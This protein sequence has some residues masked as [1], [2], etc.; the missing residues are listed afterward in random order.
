MKYYER[1]PKRQIKTNRR[2][3]KYTNNS[4]ISV[5]ELDTNTKVQ[6]A[7]AS[8]KAKG[9]LDGLK[10]EKTDEGVTKAPLVVVDLIG[11]GGLGIAIAA[12]ILSPGGLLLDIV[13]SFLTFF[14][15]YMIYQKVRL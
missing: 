5:M 15:P 10:G 1:A 13:G 9:C 3:H 4:I 6:I 12:I 2:N 8:R 14:A 11:L 7:K